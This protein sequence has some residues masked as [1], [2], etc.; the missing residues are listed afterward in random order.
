MKE[1][2]RWEVLVRL[3]LRVRKDVGAVEEW[4]A[5]WCLRAVAV[6]TGWGCWADLRVPSPQ[7]PNGRD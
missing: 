5:L 7:S 2:R 6:G 4:V 1:P 3:E